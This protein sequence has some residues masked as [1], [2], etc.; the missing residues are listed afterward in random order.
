MF[1]CILTEVINSTNH[2]DLGVKRLYR[3]IRAL[4]KLWGRGI[5]PNSVILTLN[6]PCLVVGYEGGHNLLYYVPFFVYAI[7]LQYAGSKRSSQK[8]S[9]LFFETCDSKIVM[10]QL[11]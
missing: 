10:P 1:K 4:K 7:R 8:L 11:I 5:V 3:M 9:K 2:G 6:C